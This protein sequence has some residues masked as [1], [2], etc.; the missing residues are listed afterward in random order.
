MP[1]VSLEEGLQVL[2]WRDGSWHRI[3]W[4]N[5]MSFREPDATF[6]PRDRRT[7]RM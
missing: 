7:P 1:L 4:Q 3:A 2:H 6:A 5:W